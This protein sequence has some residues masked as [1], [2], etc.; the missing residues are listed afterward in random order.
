MVTTKLNRSCRA[1][2]CG[3]AV[4]GCLATSAFAQEDNLHGTWNCSLE[5]IDDEIGAVM[6]ADFEQTYATNG[7]FERMGQMSIMI[8]AFGV[9]IAIGIEENGDWRM[10]DAMVI[11]ETTSDVAFSSQKQEPSEMEAMILQQMQAEA[12]ADTHDEST[13]ELKTLTATT[14][15]FEDEEGVVSSCQKV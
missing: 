13:V 8:E 10:V 6:K 1:L 12:D 9:D 4:M 14:M 2:F 7:T 15:E 5:F 3:V 11:G